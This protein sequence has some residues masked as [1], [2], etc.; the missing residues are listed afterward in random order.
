M[1]IKIN[2]G[3]SLVEV[4]VAVGLISMVIFTCKSLLSVTPIVRSVSNEAIALK[5]T[6]QKIEELRALGYSL[7]PASGLFSDSMLSSLPSGSASIAIS[8]YDAKTKQVVVTVSWVEPTN[9]NH[10]VT[11]ATLLAQNGGLK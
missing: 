2:N 6:S 8:D 5:I 1:K 3:F 11:L 10:T 7:L 9:G 4:L